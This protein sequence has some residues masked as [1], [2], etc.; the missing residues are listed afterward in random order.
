MLR[1]KQ[2]SMVFLFVAV[3]LANSHARSYSQAIHTDFPRF[4]VFRGAADS[5]GLP[6]SGAK[7]CLLKPA[8]V[9][10]EM[11]SHRASDSVEYEFGLDPRSESLPLAGGG[12][13]VFFSS[14]FSG[15]G[16]GTLDSLAILRYQADGKI[17]NLMPFVGVTNQSDRAVWQIASVSNFPILV[18]ADFYW[19]DGE[20]HFSEHLYTVNAYEF[21]TESDR[22][23]KVISYR[24]FK[25]YPGLDEVER[26]HILTSERA[27]ILRRLEPHSAN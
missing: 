12:S 21:D 27:Q 25:K 23:V 24:T 20:T 15:G 22:Y 14:Q 5:D 17:I 9:C 13:L 19:M 3:L 26:I 7:L 6:T 10:F 18:T 1:L 4:T 16:S 8:G 11:P 2:S